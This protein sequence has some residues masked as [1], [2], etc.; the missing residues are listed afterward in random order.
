MWSMNIEELHIVRIS[1]LIICSRE[2]L[3]QSN[4][5]WLTKLVLGIRL[6]VVWFALRITAQKMKFSINDFFS[7]CDQICSFLQNWSH[8]LKKSLMENF[9]FCAVDIFAIIKK[10]YIKTTKHFSIKV[11][12]IQMFIKTFQ[13]ADIVWRSVNYFCRDWFCLR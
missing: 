8:L 5:Y 9:I 3:W 1:C 10:I 7:K 13:E 4:L 2:Y 11:D 12:I 6:C